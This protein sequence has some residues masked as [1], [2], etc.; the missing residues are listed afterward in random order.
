VRKPAASIAALFALILSASADHGLAATS[1]DMAAQRL[2]CM[3][4]E[5]PDRVAK[6]RRVG[7]NSIPDAAD[8]CVA[9]LVRAAH[10]GHLSDLYRTLLTQLGGNVELAEKLPLAIGNAVMDGNSRV[11]ISNGK[12]IDVPPS[13]AF[14][15]G[16]TVAYLKGDA[17]ADDVDPAKL[18]LLAESCLAVNKDAGTCFSAGYT[19]GQQAVRAQGASAR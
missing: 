10:D 12:A 8:T 2:T 4:G 17:R 15:A 19:Y 5:Q 14:D 11:T 13:L 7:K 1:G 6:E 9:A 16:F 18:K 3:L